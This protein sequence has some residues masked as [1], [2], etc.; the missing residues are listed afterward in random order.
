LQSVVFQT[1]DLLEAMHSDWFGEEKSPDGLSQTKFQHKGCLRV[2]GGMSVSDW[3]MQ[4]LSNITGVQ[5][6]RP[7]VLETTALGVAWL[8][9]MHAGVYPDQE[10]FSKTWSLDKRFNPVMSF[11]DRETKYSDWKKAV[12]A[13]LLV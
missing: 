9:G 5:V 7:K 6:D 10:E 13:T 12:S 11:S 4:F 8:A 1:R 2:D 3:T